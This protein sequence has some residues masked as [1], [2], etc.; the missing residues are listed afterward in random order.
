M[1][2]PFSR[3]VAIGA[4]N[5]TR[6]LHSVVATARAAQGP[7]I[8]VF[9]ALGHGR[10]YGVPSRVLVR[11]LPSILE[12]GLWTKLDTLPRVPTR[13]LVTDVGNDILYGFSAEQT[14]AWI[15]EALRRLRRVTDDIVL[16][17]L[18]L[19]SIRRLSRARFLLFRSIL[20]PQCELSLARV[21]ETAE[22]VDAGLSRLAASSGARH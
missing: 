13:A 8:E 1:P 10:S 22:A 5:L 7:K 2:E 16:T 9:A 18:P 20:V 15:A 3:I 17:S 14:L 19:A 12:S 4:S 6:G 21:V 11:T